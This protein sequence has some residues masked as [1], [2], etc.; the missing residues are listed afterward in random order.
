MMQ[1][2]ESK[3]AVGLWRS[4]WIWGAAAMLA[5]VGLFAYI[6]T[7]SRYLADDYCDSAMLLHASFFQALSLRYQTI[8][9]RY[10]NFLLVAL[11]D[12]LGPHNIEVMPILMI[13]VWTVAVIW[14]VRSVKRS[15]GWRWSSWLDVYLGASLVFL[16]ILQ[17]PN[18]FQTIYWRSAME[19]HFA[20]LVYLTLFAAFL[21]TRIHSGGERP[22]AF[23][24][25]PFLMVAA[26]IG[27][28]FSEP[29]DA[30]L[31]VASGLA[32]LAV[33]VWIQGPRR[34]V[35]W[36]LLAWT[37][38][39]GVLALLVMKFSP[40]NSLRL[41]TPPPG[42]VTLV[43]RTLL[44]TFQFFLDT[45]TSLPVP[46]LVA[47]ALP[48]LLFY[49]LF[50]G[51]PVLSASQRRLL[52]IALVAVP[53][54]MYILSAASF[55][56]SVYGQSFP[57]ARARFAARVVMTMALI[58]EGACLGTLTAQWKRRWQPVAV[59]LAMALLAVLPLYPLRSAW[60]IE[61]DV[62]PFYRQWA[63][64]WD[65]RESQLLAQKSQGVQDI[66]LFPLISRDDIKEF[67]ANPSFWV[68]RCAATYYGVN[69][70]TAP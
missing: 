9:D 12:L 10:T 35:A 56:P 61:R 26:F 41:R 60:Q 54:L 21:L 27:G 8:S 45:L 14:L 17:A 39:G 57:E 5:G 16:A 47:A 20:P 2:P 4:L 67:D 18:R 40:A 48:F 50:A 58:S 68:N 6:G 43:S 62:L 24:M 36:S 49:G 23:W 13:L 33:W 65:V 28:G 19:T 70:I 66:H 42:L 22:P 15:A 44:Y 7:Y 31:I 46:T 52:V 38:A 3:T 11:S 55:A 69:A 34:R 63:S 29:P 32:L 37:L 25:G 53:V 1:F 64:L 30:I 59:S 51:R